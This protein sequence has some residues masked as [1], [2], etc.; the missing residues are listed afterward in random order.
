LNPGRVSA[1]LLGLAL[2]AGPSPSGPYDI[3]LKAG[4]V[5]P[6]A[7]GHARLVFAASPFG[8]AVTADGHA[9]YD[10]QL[11]L[12]GLPAPD[13]L[14]MY[15]AYVVWAVTPD[16]EPPPTVPPPWVARRSTSSCS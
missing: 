16:L 4:R 5:A 7:Q 13:S 15:S 6:T 12:S 2:L 14:G 10:V 3:P 1:A 8:I 11:T 9:S